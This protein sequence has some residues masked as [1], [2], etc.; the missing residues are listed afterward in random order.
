M[1]I[2]IGH[3]HA[4]AA[5]TPPPFY[6]VYYMYIS[7]QLTNTTLCSL[8]EKHQTKLLLLIILCEKHQTKSLLLII[9]WDG[10][11]DGLEFRELQADI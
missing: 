6:L 5:N 2:H 8:Y 10:H 4:G 7:Y 9:L 11:R 1:I 3:R